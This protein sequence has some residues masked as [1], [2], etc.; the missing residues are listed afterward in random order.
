MSRLSYQRFLITL[1]AP[2][3]IPST[4]IAHI[5]ANISNIP[6]V[7]SEDFAQR[8]QLTSAL[9]HVGIASI[10]LLLLCLI[11]LYQRTK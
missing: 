2:I 6:N 11:A 3:S 9:L 7:F 1:S 5:G 10:I 8:D 4:I